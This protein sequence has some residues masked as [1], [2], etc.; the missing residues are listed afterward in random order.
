MH[1]RNFIQSTIGTAAITALA[2]CSS[3]LGSDNPDSPE[4]TSTDNT[5]ND[6]EDTN[7]PTDTDEPD[8]TD[9]TSGEDTTGSVTLVQE[10]ATVENRDGDDVKELYL[11]GSLDNSTENNITVRL[12]F[13]F[14]FP[15]TE[16]LTSEND[17]VETTPGTSDF[18]F[19]KLPLVESNNFFSSEQKEALR[20]DDFEF[21]MWLV[22]EVQ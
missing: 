11:G 7:E 10:Y 9:N 13:T 22:E 8:S 15:N 18:Q 3:F 5:G 19:P 21:E 16:D 12:G 17:T 1:R 6:P 2:G 20:N 4:N 14:E